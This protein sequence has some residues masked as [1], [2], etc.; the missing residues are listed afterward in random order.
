[1]ADTPERVQ[2]EYEMGQDFRLVPAEG[3]FGGPTPQ[4]KLFMVFFVDHPS[5]PHVV[6]HAIEQVAGGGQLGPEVQRFGGV[7]ITRRA[8][9]GMVMDRQV[10]ESFLQWLAVQVAAMRGSG[11]GGERGA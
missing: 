4:G 11:D 8:E 10:A 1:M 3:V 2:F 7:G 9:V 6:E 5:I